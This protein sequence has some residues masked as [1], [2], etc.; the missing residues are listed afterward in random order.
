MQ[1]IIGALQ[2]LGPVLEKIGVAGVLAAALVY[3]WRENAK[4]KKELRATYR[5]RARWRDA[6]AKQKGVIDLL[7]F[8]I[9]GDVE[10]TAVPEPDDE[11]TEDEE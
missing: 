4:L 3:L 6:F 10:V 5:S 7:N 11:D 2:T 8:K 9:K 1:E